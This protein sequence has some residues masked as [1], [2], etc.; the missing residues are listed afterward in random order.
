MSK[1]TR[2]GQRRRVHPSRALKAGGNSPGRLLDRILKTPHLAQV[3][4]RLQPDVLHRVIQHCGLEDCGELVALATPEQL[5]RVF[6]LDLWRTDRPG[7]DE[8][9]D[10]DRFG[11]WL[12]V[13]VESGA[14]VAAATLAAM[15]ADLAIVALARHFSY[16][17][18][19]PLR[20]MS[21]STAKW[22]GR[23]LFNDSLRCEV[24]GYVVV[25]RRTEC[26]DAIEAVLVV[27]EAAN[28]GYFGQ[29]MDG[30]RRLSN[31]LPEVDGLHDLL[32]VGDQV[33]FEL[34]IDREQRRDTQGYVTSA[35]ARAFLEMSRRIDLRP[36]ATAPR[37]PVA[38]A[39]FRDTEMHTAMEPISGFGRLPARDAHEPPDVAANA[40]VDLLHEA[41]I[42]PR[43]ARALLERPDGHESRLAR[44]RARMQFPHDHDPPRIRGGVGARVPG[45]RHRRGIVHSGTTAPAEEASNAAVAVCNLGLENWSKAGTALPED[46]LVRH[47]LVSVFQVG[48]TILHENV[49]MYAAERLIDVLTSLRCDDRE[50]QSALTTLR[51]TMAKHWRAGAPWRA[52]D[53]LDVI[54]ILD[55]PTWVG[56][57]DLIDEFPVLH[58][59][60][61]ASLNREIRGMS[62]S[63]FEFFSEDGQVS[64]VH[65]F[66]RS[67]PEKLRG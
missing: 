38:H 57:L 45:E 6:D 18:M 33:M 52:R 14:S 61:D 27:L 20:R 30:C 1:R 65:E 29:V 13:M 46:F 51:I 64:R 23:H 42:L 7:L 53:A 31:S 4:P 15:D 24:G 16:S 12:E 58:A 66:M 54:A 67:L 3:V 22:S 10:A 62:A 32:T 48:W 63:A 9:F 2:R 59:A 25:A 47:D 55:M 37:S 44:I 28:P 36:G 49:C 8:Q 17:T 60:V 40:V 50:T 34:A 19:R 35:Q 39:Y 56:C 21:H 41:G 11:V 5:A 43:N 26:W